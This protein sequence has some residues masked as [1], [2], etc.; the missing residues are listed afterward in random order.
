MVSGAQRH[1]IRHIRTATVSPP[2]DVVWLAV[3][4]AHA[5]SGYRA[6]GVHH[7]QR[8]PLSTVGEPDGAP[9]V[10]LRGGVADLDDDTG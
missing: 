5:A 9:E 3:V 10:Q 2:D 4:V 8:T 6:S 1:Q 7:S